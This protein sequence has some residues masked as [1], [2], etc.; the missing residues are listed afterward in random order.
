VKIKR[1]AYSSMNPA[2]FNIV[3]CLLRLQ[4]RSLVGMRIRDEDVDRSPGLLH[5][6]NIPLFSDWEY[7]AASSF[8]VSIARD[9]L[10]RLWSV[11][12]NR[13]KVGLSVNKKAIWADVKG[14]I[15]RR[16]LI[17]GR[18]SWSTTRLFPAPDILSRPFANVKV[19]GDPIE[20]CCVLAFG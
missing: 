6:T 15:T 19:V 11:M 7:P 3:K 16:N 17:S 18:S 1:A 12:S 8:I 13:H 2:G 9:M 10:G 14:L 4:R 5:L 20:R